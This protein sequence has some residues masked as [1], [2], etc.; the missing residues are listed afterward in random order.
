MVNPSQ[1]PLKPALPD[2]PQPLPLGKAHARDA[3]SRPAG[4]AAQDERNPA[5]WQAAKDFEAVFVRQLLAVM[6]AA[7]PK[8]GLVGDDSA[9]GIYEGMLDAAVADNVAASGNLGIAAA[10]YRQFSA[11]TG[12][13]R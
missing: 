8:E 9:R 5:L 11:A 12:G 3:A 7:G 4:A 13:P 1:L 2:L 10:V 6:R